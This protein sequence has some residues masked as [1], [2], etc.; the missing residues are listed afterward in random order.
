MRNWMAAA[1]ALA[2]AGCGGGEAVPTPEQ[3]AQAAQETLAI[4]ARVA[5]LSP[6]QRNGV[7]IR[8]I[9]DAGLRCQGVVNSER[10][11]PPA[12]ATW[13]ARCTNGSGHI[14]AFGPNGMAKVTSALRR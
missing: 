11:P 7:F 10:A 5:A 1:A 14:I 2:L 9:R 13:I 4:E 3:N 8:A 12:R 6:G